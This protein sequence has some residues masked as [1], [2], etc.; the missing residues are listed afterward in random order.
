MMATSGGRRKRQNNIEQGTGGAI[1]TNA[2]I[3]AM[4]AICLAI[5]NSDNEAFTDIN[6]LRD[7]EDRAFSNVLPLCPQSRALLRLSPMFQQDQFTIQPG[8]CYR[9]ND[10][11]TPTNVENYQ[12]ASVCCY[13]PN[14]NG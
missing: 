8:D 2:E 10:L 13:D 14:N 3:Q 1:P 4:R 7:S 9:S 12:F 5:A 11:Y 6:T